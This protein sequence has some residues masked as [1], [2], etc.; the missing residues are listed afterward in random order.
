MATSPNQVSAQ[1][2]EVKPSVPDDLL[3]RA[4]TL[5]AKDL[6]RTAVRIFGD[7]LV[8]TTSFGA[9]SAVMLHLV[10]RVIPEIPVIWIDTGYLFPETYRFAGELTER[11]NLNL[12]I[13]QSP[14]SPA[15][16]EAL[17]GR[18]WQS[19][20]PETLRHYD[21]VRKVEPMQ[22]ALRDLE[23]HGWLAG[24]RRDQTD[25]RR[26]LPRVQLQ[27][28]VY[29]LFP[30]LGWSKRD[31]HQYLTSHDLPYHPLFDRGY[32]SIGDWHSSEPLASHHSRERD[33]RFRGIK[34]EC[35]LHLDISEQAAKSLDSSGL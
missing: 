1:V 21:H 27:G 18:L 3:A 25:F 10:T 6:V 30:I 14:M 23:V 13:Y 20:D 7:R 35:G 8:M 33:T 5:S 28:N 31:L 26:S 32:V 9:H 15:R 11:L 22:R 34:Q 12:R 24:L 19:K 2:R 29:K 16:M 4:E 17:H